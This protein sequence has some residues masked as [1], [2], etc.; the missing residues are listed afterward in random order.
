MDLLV[1][2]D[3]LI[4]QYAVANN[5]IYGHPA[6]PN[7]VAVGA[8]DA[9]DSGHN[10]IESYSSRGPV[11]I[12][13]PSNETRQKPDLCGIDGVTVTGAGGFPSPFYG[14]SAAAPHIAGLAALLMGGFAVNAADTRSA[15]YNQAID[16]GATGFDTTYGYG[17]ADAL[18]AAAALDGTAPESTITSPATSMSITEGDSVT[19]SGECT[20]AFSTTGM[21]FGWDFGGAGVPGSALQNPGALTFAIPGTYTVSFTCTDGFG[22]ADSTPATQT[23]TVATATG[24]DDDPAT[25]SSGGGCQI[26]AR[27]TPPLPTLSIILLTLIAF[28][29][30]RRTTCGTMPK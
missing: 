23:I 20:D 1:Y 22:T 18:K 3:I 9:G 30:F 29:V 10:S 17:R 26:Q 15:L 28:W 27:Q 6:V 5:S 8:I 4:L 11:E 12:F 25:T 24:V 21:T 16:L 14:T 7:V 13:F 19:F 2:G